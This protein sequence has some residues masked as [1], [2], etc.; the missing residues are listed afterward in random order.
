MATGIADGSVDRCQ[1]HV[2]HLEVDDDHKDDNCRDQ[3]RD[4]WQVAAV[5]RILQ[6]FELVVPGQHEVEQSDDGALKLCATGTLDGV[7]REGLPNDVLT[8]VGG[9]EEGDRRAHAVALLEELVQAEHN[10]SGNAELHRQWA[11]ECDVE[12]PIARQQCH[13]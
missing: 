8:D 12:E 1:G 9:N 6:R 4:V 7:G 10:D 5:E 11:G 2:T 3:R 13:A